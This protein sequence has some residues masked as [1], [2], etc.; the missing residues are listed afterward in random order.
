MSSQKTSARQDFI[1]RQRYK[2]T[3]PP[4]PF[5]PK[6]LDAPLPLKTYLSPFST[7]QII[8]SLPP[9]MEL[10]AENGMPLDLSLIEGL[11]EGDERG[12]YGSGEKLDEE[13]ALL[14]VDPDAAHS[15]ANKR[16]HN[17]NFLRRTEYIST[18][19]SRTKH[20]SSGIR[21]SQRE[22]NAYEHL[23]SLADPEAQVAAIER[24]FEVADT[25]LEQMTHPLNRT[26]TALES[27]PIIPDQILSGQQLLH[28][29]FNEPPL[30]N[31]DSVTNSLLRAAASASE[32]EYFGY[33]APNGGDAVRVEEGGEAA[34]R[35]VRDYKYELIG[36]CNNDIIIIPS[37]GPEKVW[38][39]RKYVGKA[40]LKRSRQLTEAKLGM[41]RD[42]VVNGG[43]PVRINVRW[44]GVG[45][46]GGATAGEEEA[47]GEDGAQG[48]G[49]DEMEE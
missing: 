49:G 27:W 26:L 48:A 35:H 21:T 39:Y 7:S 1:V 5:P 45:V 25:P 18:E 10:D 37:E 17:E 24:T 31:T 29:R 4:P 19:S 30:S 40:T 14:C 42:G 16:A 15:S 38:A 12:L 3:L 47:L 2:N 23:S 22:Q 11:F 9:N 13:D 28:I 6:L 36:D 41:R 8:R 44:K 46:G 43:D 20:K 32:D 34:Y 33:Y